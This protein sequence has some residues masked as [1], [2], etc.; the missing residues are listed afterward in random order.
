MREH[1]GKRRGAGGVSNRCP[2]RDRRMNR[3]RAVGI[4]V[5]LTALLAG[6][7]P[8][9]GAQTA[10]PAAWAVLI[11]S[12]SYHG[13]YRDLPV[14]YI[15]STRLLTSLARRGWPVDH[16]LL[17]RDS[18]DRALLGHATDWLAARVRPGDVALLYVAG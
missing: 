2:E 5:L 3:P 4:V 10:A 1:R 14:G 6:F 16:I 15:N 18:T 17:I 7:P 9:T 13:R 12:N 8:V 11:E